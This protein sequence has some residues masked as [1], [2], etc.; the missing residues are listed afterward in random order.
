MEHPRI[1]EQID[2]MRSMVARYPNDLQI[3]PATNH[4]MLRYFVTLV[5]G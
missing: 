5:I 1:Q 2:L 3:P 4:V